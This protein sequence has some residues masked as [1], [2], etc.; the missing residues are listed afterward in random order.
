MKDSNTVANI[1]AMKQPQRE[2]LLV[3]KRQCMKESNTRVIIAAMK[4]LEKNHLPDTTR[5]YINILRLP[6]LI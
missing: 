4:Q 3:T 5:L 2:V 1:A 6:I